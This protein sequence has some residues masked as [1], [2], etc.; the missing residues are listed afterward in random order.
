M[1]LWILT[2][3]TWLALGGAGGLYLGWRSIEGQAPV[4]A[5]GNAILAFLIG[6]LGGAAI[7]TLAWYLLSI[8]GGVR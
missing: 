5:I 8:I 1:P 6:A 3:V 2:L 7:W 4:N